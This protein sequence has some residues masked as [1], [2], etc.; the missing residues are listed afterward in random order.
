MKA[1]SIVFLLGCLLGLTQVRAIWSHR[2]S[3]YDEPGAWWPHSEAAWRGWVRGLPV[4]VLGGTLLGVTSAVGAFTGVFDSD[5]AVTDSA[6]GMVVFALAVASISTGVLGMS[7]VFL[8]RPK[9]VVPP[10]LRAGPG[11]IS[12]WRR[13]RRTGQGN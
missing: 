7:A 10:Y 11:L 12:E 4:S 6:A 1:L 3:F 2:S 9:W 13:L 5:A 8:N